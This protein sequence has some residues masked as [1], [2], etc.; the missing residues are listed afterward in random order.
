[1]RELNVRF[2]VRIA[3][4]LTI[5]PIVLS[6]RT[7]YFPTA[8]L[9]FPV[10]NIGGNVVPIVT[11]SH[12][13][14]SSGNILRSLSFEAGDER[15]CPHYTPLEEEDHL[16]AY[17]LSLPL[18]NLAIKAF[19]K[20]QRNHVSNPSVGSNR[21]SHC[22]CFGAWYPSLSS[23]LAEPPVWFEHTT[24]PVLIVPN[25]WLRFD[26]SPKARP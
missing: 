8:L 26:L 10:T 1:M 9:G 6:R 5:C 22:R 15:G 20:E 18:E 11:P 25:R 23:T 3:A 2:A 4:Q 13:S 12:P 16:L 7:L 21:S 24:V 19:I 17:R 14:L